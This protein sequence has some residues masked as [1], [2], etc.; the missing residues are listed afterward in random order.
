MAEGED[1]FEGSINKALT[2][3]AER[4]FSRELQQ[5]QKSSVKQ[6]FTGGDL[7]A[8]LPTGEKSNF[9]SV[10]TCERRLCCHCYKMGLEGLCDSYFVSLTKRVYRK[11]YVMRNTTSCN[12]IIQISR[13]RH[14][15]HQQ[16]NSS[17]SR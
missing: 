6:L 14:Y 8:V 12:R 5:E 9:S 1:A 3:L 13:A 16:G 11:H 7:F 4:G 17:C 15:K 10:S 2:F